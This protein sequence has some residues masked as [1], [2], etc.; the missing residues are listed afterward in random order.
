MSDTLPALATGLVKG[1]EGFSSKPYRCPAGVWTIGYGSTHDAH[2][3]PVT[4]HTPNVT[5]EAAT[6]L[7]EAVLRVLDGEVAGV[8]HVPLSE[9]QRAAI[10]SF[11]Y[12]LGFHSFSSSTLL[13][14]LNAK[15][16]RAA[17]S[18]F[19]RWDHINGKPSAGLLRR[20]QEEQKVFLTPSASAAKTAS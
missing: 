15:D 7:L 8:V 20:R 11:V 10:L 14:R 12:N 9:P 19:L 6:S 4:P 5:E 2:G 17:A 13:R 1:F 18:E 3:A 16:Y